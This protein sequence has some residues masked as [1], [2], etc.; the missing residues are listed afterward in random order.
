MKSR[1]AVAIIATIALMSAC[2]T[3]GWVSDG[4]VQEG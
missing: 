3:A 1:K 2:G 4:T